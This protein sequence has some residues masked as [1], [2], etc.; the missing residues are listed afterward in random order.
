[1]Q[2]GRSANRAIQRPVTFPLPDR[3]NPHELS[4]VK[5]RICSQR[6][7]VLQSAMVA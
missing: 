2:R 6:S 7:I 3:S 5:R 4:L 1:V